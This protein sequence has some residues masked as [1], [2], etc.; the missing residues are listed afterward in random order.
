MASTTSLPFIMYLFFLPVLFA[1]DEV[2]SKGVSQEGNKIPIFNWVD[3]TKA[4]NFKRIRKLK[5]PVLIQGNLPSK[6]WTAFK[7]WKNNDYLAKSCPRLT[8]VCVRH[9]NDTN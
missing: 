8:Q 7:K 3:G 6:V 1:E 9:L 4:F 2:S 5:T